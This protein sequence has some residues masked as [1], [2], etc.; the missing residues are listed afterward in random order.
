MSGEQNFWPTGTEP[1]FIHSYSPHLRIP[2]LEQHNLGE[3]NSVLTLNNHYKTQHIR[4]SNAYKTWRLGCLGKWED[5]IKMDLREICCERF[6]T[7]K[8]IVSIVSTVF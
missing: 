7:W 1:I 3:E 8:Q 2:C 4:I 5:N 6:F